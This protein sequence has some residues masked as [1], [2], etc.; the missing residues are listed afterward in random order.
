MRGWTRYTVNLIRSLVETG[1]VEIFLITDRPMAEEHRT[2]L[3]QSFE[4]GLLHEVA[5][6]PM[7]YPKWQE[8]WLPQAIKS[9]KISVYHTPYHYGIPWRAGCPT[10]AT[11]HDAIDATMKLPWGQRFSRVALLSR[12]YLWQS[13]KMASSVITVSQFSAGELSRS[14]KIPREKIRVVYEAADPVFD[15]KANEAQIAEVTQRYA[16]SLKPYVFYVGGLEE[17]KNFEVVLHAMASMQHKPSFL[18]ALAGGAEQD[19]LRLAELAGSLGVSADV[20]FLGKVPDTDL[21]ALYAGSLALVYPSRLEGFGLQLVEAMAC[22]CPLLVSQ[23]TSLPEIAGQAADYFLPDDSS[24]LAAMFERLVVDSDFPSDLKHRSMERSR[25]FSW[26]ATALG[27]LA[28]YR[29]L[30][31]I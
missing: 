15:Q 8:R 26:A 25:D 12:Y 1:E 31:E 24:A 5:S 4:S 9:N 6:G 10:V 20:K 11:L 29:E 23:A 16:I 18:L 22:G 27:T 13:R 7:A 28:V 2:A 17:R 21:P 3:L 14:L 30:A 19:R